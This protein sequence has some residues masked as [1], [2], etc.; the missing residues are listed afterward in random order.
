M[1]KL[2]IFLIA[3]PYFLTAQVKN[4]ATPKNQSPNSRFVNTQANSNKIAST[5]F[6]YDAVGNVTKD[7][8]QGISNINYASFSRMERDPYVGGMTSTSFHLPRIITFLDG[9][10]IK[11]Q[12]DASGKKLV[13]QLLINDVISVEYSYLGNLTYIRTP[14][15][16]WKL[17]E[18]K[19]DE[20]RLVPKSENSTEMVYEYDIEDQTGSPRVSFRENTTTGQAEIVRK[21]DFDPFGLP[22]KGIDYQSPTIDTLSKKYFF[23]GKEYLVTFGLKMYDYGFR[24]Y[25]PRLGRYYQID[26]KASM[27]PSWSPYSFSFDNPIRYRDYDGQIPY[28]I[29][30]R[31][32]APFS[33]FG[34]GFHGDNRGYSTSASA[35][36]RVHQ[37]LN[38]ETDKNYLTG[39]S[40]SSP[41]WHTLLPSYQRTATA[42]FDISSFNSENNS[43]NFSTHASAGNPITPKSGTPD[44]DVFSDFSITSQKGSLSISGKLTGDNFPSTEAFISDPGGQNVFLGIGQIGKGVDKDSGPFTELPN[45]N[46]GNPITSFNLTIGTDKKGNFTNITSGGKTYTIDN[47]NKMYS[48]TSPTR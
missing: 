18:M 30:V 11:N 25:N 41:T 7:L 46:R 43:F 19:I 2:F 36:A 17:I 37:R 26:P 6:E 34:L 27:M 20:G 44:I 39:S 45:E 24:T 31:S 47:W 8:T 35:T 40:W 28:P 29:T 48:T 14:G 21:Q 4:P 13:T 38:F 16:D 23:N 33:N 9:R 3:T 15:K 42:K 5:D 1:R 10:K 22:L 12:Y 32:F